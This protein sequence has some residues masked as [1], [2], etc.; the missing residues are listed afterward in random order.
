MQQSPTPQPERST[1]AETF[2]ADLAA[3]D[4]ALA[5]VEVARRDVFGVDAAHPSDADA[6]LMRVR[7]LRM[8]ALAR[9]LRAMR[10]PA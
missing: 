4:R 3:F 7:A 10:A 8:A 6:M 5:D 2:A 9:G 1:A